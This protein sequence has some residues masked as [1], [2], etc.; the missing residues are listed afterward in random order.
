MKIGISEKTNQDEINFIKAVAK[1]KI[2]SY[3]TL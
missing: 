1:N 3:F 2:E